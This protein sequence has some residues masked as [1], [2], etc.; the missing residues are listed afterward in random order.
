MCGRGPDGLARG[1]ILRL[2]ELRSLRQAGAHRVGNILLAA[3][4]S[5]YL[6]GTLVQARVSPSSRTCPRHPCLKSTGVPSQR[7][8]LLLPSRQIITTRGQTHPPS[9]LNQHYYEESHPSLSRPITN[10]DLSIT[11]PPPTPAPAPYEE[12]HIDESHSIG[13]GSSF[14]AYPTKVS[15]PRISFQHG[16]NTSLLAR[17]HKTGSI[18]GIA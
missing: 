18:R 6:E 2:P 8:S 14:P 13:C 9:V 15:P 3:Y 7:R 12:I 1:R 11:L 17:L 10:T 5:W 16:S 4:D